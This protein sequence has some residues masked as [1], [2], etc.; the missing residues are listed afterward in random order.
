MMP[1]GC[2]KVDQSRRGE[3]KKRKKSEWDEV[4]H[5]SILLPHPPPT[6]LHR[7]LTRGFDARFPPRGGEFD[8]QIPYAS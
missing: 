8:S 7:G 6:G 4:M 2:K 5:L 3:Y 1:Q